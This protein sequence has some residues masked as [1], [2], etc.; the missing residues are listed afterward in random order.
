MVVNSSSVYQLPP[1]LIMLKDNH[2]Q[3]YAPT[4]IGAGN[5]SIGVREKTCGGTTQRETCILGVPHH[6]LMIAVAKLPCTSIS[7]PLVVVFVPSC[8]AVFFE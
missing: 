4:R 2:V 1:S 6:F 7:V 5:G 8:L 3:T